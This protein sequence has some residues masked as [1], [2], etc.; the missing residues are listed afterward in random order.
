MSIGTS[1]GATGRVLASRSN[2]A[3]LLD[4]RKSG[5]GLVDGIHV[6]GTLQNPRAYGHG[7]R[8]TSDMALKLCRTLRSETPLEE[9]R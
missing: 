2:T 3:G 7:W 8:G 9:W 6:A 1:S 5:H 4:K